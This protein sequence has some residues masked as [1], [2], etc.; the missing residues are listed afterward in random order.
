MSGVYFP[1]PVFLPCYVAGSVRGA[2][3]YLSYSSIT[4]AWHRI[5]D[6]YIY[7]LNKWMIIVSF[8]PSPFSPN[9]SPLNKITIM[10]VIETRIL[11]LEWREV[12]LIYQDKVKIWDCRTQTGTYTLLWKVSSI[13]PTHR[14]FLNDN[15]QTILDS[16]CQGSE[17]FI[18]AFTSNSQ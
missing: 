9:W 1:F 2:D 15:E 5:N 4:R 6:R 8:F 18:I 16:R 14:G 11:F 10:F 3:S 13:P 7:L 12:L 17:N